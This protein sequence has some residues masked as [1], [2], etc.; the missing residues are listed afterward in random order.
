MYHGDE[1]LLTNFYHC[2]GGLHCGLDVGRRCSPR[3]QRMPNC[4]VRMRP[5]PVSSENR[6]SCLDQRRV[7]TEAVQ[8]RVTHVRRHTS[9][10]S[11]TR[12]CCPCTQRFDE[13]S[14][15]EKTKSSKT[16][17][18]GH[19]TP[20]TCLRNHMQTRKEEKSAC[21]TKKWIGGHTHIWIYD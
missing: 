20:T 10:E 16:R 5:R 13:R 21:T 19:P 4:H 15:L 11:Y 2:P 6:P 8:C 1:I 12:S 14:C 7:V 9:V 18:V 3:H 17:S